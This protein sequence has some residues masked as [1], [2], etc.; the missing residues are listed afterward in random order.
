MANVIANVCKHSPKSK[1]R[2][3]KLSATISGINDVKEAITIASNEQKF[4]RYTVM[5][6]DEIHRFNKI[7]QDTFLPHV[8]AG[9]ITLIG[10]TTENPSYSLN[11]AL[12]SRCRVIVLEKLSV[13]N[14]E[15]ILINAV[16]NLN[17]SISEAENVCYFIYFKI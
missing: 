13:E 16:K 14:L 11:A 5:F 7:Q 8:E 9:T 1:H 12:L 4:G 10:A 6:I 17:G 2:F 15:D 3:V